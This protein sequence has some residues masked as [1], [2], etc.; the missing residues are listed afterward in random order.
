[1]TH[2]TEAYSRVPR[3]LPELNCNKNTIKT[4]FVACVK[5]VGFL[6]LKIKSIKDV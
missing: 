4:N 5:V 1:M 6:L 2:H 3:I